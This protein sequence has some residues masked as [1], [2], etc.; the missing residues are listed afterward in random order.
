MYLGD[1][2]VVFAGFKYQAGVGGCVDV[3]FAE[4]VDELG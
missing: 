4:D 3:A 2:P 1:E